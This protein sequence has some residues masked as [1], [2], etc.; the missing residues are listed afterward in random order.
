ML[1]MLST[2][3]LREMASNPNKDLLYDQ[4]EFHSIQRLKIRYGHRFFLVKWKKCA[5]AMD[6]TVYSVNPKD[7]EIQMETSE[8]SESADPLNEID[9]PQICLD[10]GCWFLAIDENME[11][12][13]AAFPEKVDRFL[14]EKVH[15][16]FNPFCCFQP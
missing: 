11:L 13:K 8:H 1:P 14:K 2:I 6:T 12:V 7:S 3:F 16:Y 4:Y 10:D 5:P 9:A 15:F